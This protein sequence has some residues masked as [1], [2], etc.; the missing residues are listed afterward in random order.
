[1]SLL[2]L[3]ALRKWSKKFVT[4]KATKSLWLYQHRILDRVRAAERKRKGDVRL[5]QK[6][7]EEELV[8]NWERRLWLS[9][10]P[11]G[12]SVSDHSPFSDLVTKLHIPRLQG[13]TWF[14]VHTKGKTHVWSLKE[15]AGK[16]HRLAL[17]RV[18]ANV[19]TGHLPLVPLF[20]FP[21]L[22]W[23]WQHPFHGLCED[24]FS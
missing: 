6:V 17:R 9:H 20:L 22:N 16:G 1:M 11:W 10:W 21:H 8:L 24:S 23:T 15:N 19:T 4:W 3:C 14:A 7:R 5:R 12:S 13:Q 2:S 18:S